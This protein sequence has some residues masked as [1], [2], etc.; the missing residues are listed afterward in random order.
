MSLLLIPIAIAAGFLIPV[1]FGVNSQLRNYSGGPV[2]AAAISFLV[3]TLILLVAVPVSRERLS[4][5]RLG[6]ARVL[7]LLGSLAADVRD[8]A[9]DGADHV[10]QRD[11]GGI[12]C[13]PVA[14]V[15]APLALHEAG[16]LQVEQ[17]VFQELERD[18]LRGRDV[19]TLDR[20]LAGSRR[21]LGARAHGVVDLGGD[22]HAG[23]I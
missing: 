18:L 14:A 7:D 9:L 11:L 10:S 15:G 6:H 2:T 8:R 20:P 12:L 23:E 1:Q 4:L 21:K 19:V 13:Q 16:V 22:S 3:G 5:Q 17:D